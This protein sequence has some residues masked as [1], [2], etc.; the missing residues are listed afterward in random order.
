PTP[1]GREVALPARAS[2]AIHKRRAR[3][4]KSTD[5]PEMTNSSRS[6]SIG[7]RVPIFTT[8]SIRQLHHHAITLR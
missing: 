5:K 4:K 6:A 3:R 1:Y 2:S 8:N 7:N